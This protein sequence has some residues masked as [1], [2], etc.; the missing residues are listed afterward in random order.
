VSK[1]EAL[2]YLELWKI[3]EQAQQIYELV[4]GRMLDLQKIAQELAALEAP[5][6]NEGFQGM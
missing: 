2:R 5:K 1:E 6:R 4:G 3:K